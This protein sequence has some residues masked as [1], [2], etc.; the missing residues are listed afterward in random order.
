MSRVTREDKKKE[1]YNAF[2]HRGKIYK[3]P[4][5]VARIFGR[6]IG[7][8]KEFS[9]LADTAEWKNT[10]AEGNRRDATYIRHWFLLS[11]KTGRRRY[12]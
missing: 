8:V 3:F 7:S 2:H 10:F 12:L 11:W 5:V 1:H 6:G 9:I 4:P